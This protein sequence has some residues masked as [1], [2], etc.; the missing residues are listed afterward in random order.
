MKYV[1]AQTNLF[2]RDVKLAQKQGRDIQLLE[3]V[4]SELAEG[5]PLPL[6]NRD[7]ALIGEWS[8]YR[9]CHI[10]PDWLLIY[11]LNKD[12]LILTLVRTGTHSSL[13]HYS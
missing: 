4:V 10:Q 7:H 5:H 6:K 2:K 1:P 13:F 12:I 8:G 3:D 11:Y 9:E